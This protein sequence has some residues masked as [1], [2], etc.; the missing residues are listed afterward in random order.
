MVRGTPGTHGIGTRHTSIATVG[1]ITCN[2][3]CTHVR[4]V[5][6]LINAAACT[7]H[8][9]INGTVH[10]ATV[11]LCLFGTLSLHTAR[12][13]WPSLGKT[14]TESNLVRR[15]AAAAATVRCRSSRWRRRA[16]CKHD[17]ARRYSLLLHHKHVLQLQRES[18]R[19]GSNSGSNPHL[20]NNERCVVVGG[21]WCVVRGGGWCVVVPLDQHTRTVLS[22]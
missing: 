2:T 10:C 19:G 15:T 16:R 9:P 13:G 7:A 22:V 17:T 11:P 8:D 12:Y 21:W 6:L 1:D 14:C 18:S 20:P 5:S 4:V 3:A